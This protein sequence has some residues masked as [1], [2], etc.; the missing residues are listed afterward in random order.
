MKRERDWSRVPDVCLT[1]RQTGRLTVGR[2]VTLSL[3]FT[4]LWRLVRILPV[5]QGVAVGGKK[6]K[7]C[8][9]V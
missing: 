4:P 8:V 1:R 2:N 9:G 7:Q 6:E 3:A 5:A